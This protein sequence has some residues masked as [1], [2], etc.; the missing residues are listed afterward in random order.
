MT[1]TTHRDSTFAPFPGSKRRRL[2]GACDICRHK[3]SHD[4][5]AFE[6]EMDAQMLILTG[7]S[8]L[9]PGNRCS[10]CIAF[11]SECT[12][13][14]SKKGLGNNIL[15]ASNQSYV[16]GLEERVKALERT[17]Q[18]LRR[19]SNSVQEFEPDNADLQEEPPAEGVIML[20]SEC[21]PRPVFEKTSS[22]S[23][24]SQDSDGVDVDELA[25]ELKQLHILP[26]ARFFG[27]SSGYALLNIA[28][29]VKQEYTNLTSDNKPDISR[30]AN[31]AAE[32]THTT[33]S[34]QFPEPSL[35]DSLVETYF[36]TINLTIPL[37]HRPMFE[38]Q[39][40]AK[41]HLRDH[42]FGSVVL[43]ICAIA[44]RYSDDPRVIDEEG[45]DPSLATGEKWFS[46]IP[47]VR[48]SFTMSEAPSLYELQFYSLAVLYYQ[49][50]ANPQAC[51]LMTGIGMR[52]A[53]EVGAHRRTSK[54][55]R[56][57][58][59]DELWKRAFWQVLSLFF[60]DRLLCAYVGRPCTIHAEDYDVEYPVEV[61]DE[62]WTNPD[63]ELAFM[64]PPGKLSSITA[65][66]L[67]IKL[68][69]ILGTVLRLLYPTNKSK[70][71]MG[72]SGMGVN[73]ERKIVA[74]LDS[75]LN[76]WLDSVP[77]LLRW[78]PQSDDPDI[79]SLSAHL[80]CTY[81]Y[82][83]ILV[84]RPFISA[85]ASG[86]SFPSLSICV[87]AARSCAHLLDSYMSFGFGIPAPTCQ[88][89]A[90]TASIVL[91]INIWGAK[92]SHISFNT[93]KE[94]ADVYKL[95][96]VLKVYETR[97]RVSGRLWD[98]INVLAKMDQ[99]PFPE[100]NTRSNKRPPPAQQASYTTPVT[101]DGIFTI[102]DLLGSPTPTLSSAENSHID[103]PTPLFGTPQTHSHADS[104]VFS[105]DEL[106]RL[107]V[108]NSITLPR[109]L[110][111]DA[112]TG[113][114]PSHAGQ[115]SYASHL[116]SQPRPQ[117]YQ[118]E[119][120]LNT[121]VAAYPALAV[122][123]DETPNSQALRQASRPMMPTTV[124]D[125]SPQNQAKVASEPFH[126]FD[127]T[128]GGGE[129]WASAIGGFD[130]DVWNGYLASFDAN[131]FV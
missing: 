87:N 101:D 113:Q 38:S 50:T 53:Q 7:D 94:M 69:E 10:N 124:Y 2:Q 128:A 14:L 86:L 19:E 73:T 127:G 102:A 37:L 29:G 65:F 6:I 76:K 108:F 33:T 55:D 28:M 80:F 97:W 3:K 64:Q 57:T 115:Y 20:G 13:N 95:M 119:Y 54:V 5:H 79:H 78:K 58:V 93:D 91:L 130:L 82:I 103:V 22:A 34:F 16:T 116:S 71:W 75:Q 61:D 12:H 36:D 100:S 83:Q 47:V 96:H 72:V 42:W 90:F 118:D 114:V 104:N 4:A 63:P 9:M 129:L 43:A 123:P 117:V 125:I 24:P 89:V 74:E 23:P 41:L 121:P 111:S 99:L 81:Y 59:Q 8:A 51:W 88:I 40:A 15:S 17:I 44:S 131:P 67:L 11:D 105:S 21:L 112:V 56:P 68:G 98:K 85:K 1:S 46:Q 48:Q 25:D 122:S 120:F 39:L 70:L 126:L 66:N 110:T 84:H 49:G 18:E 62:Y 32:K 52:Y 107:P 35:L 30:A 26:V 106:A 45:M 77:E 31:A 27:K 109:W 60:S 92:K